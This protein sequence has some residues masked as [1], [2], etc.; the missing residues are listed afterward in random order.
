MAEA[1]FHSIQPSAPDAQ[2]APYPVAR[3]VELASFSAQFYQDIINQEEITDAFSDHVIST[4][5]C[6]NVPENPKKDIVIEEFRTKFKLQYR[7]CSYVEA[8]KRTTRSEKGSHPA[9]ISIG[10]NSDLWSYDLK[11]S[12]DWWEGSREVETSRKVHTCHACNGQ[13]FDRCGSCHGTGRV[14]ED[15]NEATCGSCSGRGFRECCACNATGFITD[16][17]LVVAEYKEKDDFHFEG[18]QVGVPDEKLEDVSGIKMFNDE[19][20]PFI[21][22]IPHY[23]ESATLDG[24]VMSILQKHHEKYAVKKSDYKRVLKQKHSLMAIPVS[25]VDLTYKEKEY[26]AWV[27]GSEKKVYCPEMKKCCSIL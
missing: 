25:E 23:P 11:P 6:F 16:I 12:C 10:S 15:G 27:Y 13:K 19:Q 8:R 26:K 7:L 5:C 1:E 4:S 9:H 20:Y 24:A 2:N 14:G 3:P 22:P 17:N 21:P 18:S